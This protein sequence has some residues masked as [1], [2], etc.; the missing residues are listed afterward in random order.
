MRLPA[1]SWLGLS[2]SEQPRKR[3]LAW[4]GEGVGSGKDTKYTLL[5]NS[6]GETW[7]G[8]PLSIVDVVED[9][10]RPDSINVWYS[11]SYDVNML[12]RNQPK[13]T[14]SE[15][16]AATCRMCGMNLQAKDS[17]PLCK[18]SKDGKG[19]HVL[20]QTVLDVGGSDYLIEYFPKKIFRVTDSERN[21]GVHYDSFS[22][23]ARSFIK[24][25]AMCK[26]PVP[27][28]ITDGKA[29]RDNFSAWK[30]E[31]IQ[32]YN[33]AEVQS[34]VKVMDMLRDALDTIGY[35]DLSGWHGP[36]AIASAM[37]DRLGVYESM[38]GDAVRKSISKKLYSRLAG[39]KG[40]AFAAYYGGRNELIRRGEVKP[41]EN[42]D[43]QSAYPAATRELPAF[44]VNWRNRIEQIAA[45]KKMEDAVAA[46]WI[47]VE[48]KDAL[49]S[50]FG[51]VDV[52]WKCDD[53]QMPLGPFPFRVGFNS[54]LPE[55]N[56]VFPSSLR[57]SDELKK[58]KKNSILYPPVGQGSY[59]L[60]EVR[61]AVERG[62]W[63]VEIGKG[64]A[65]KAGYEKPLYEPISAMMTK[66]IQYKKDG[67]FAHLPI[68]LGAN[69]FFGKFAQKFLETREYG[70]YNNMLCAG[71]IMAWCRAEIMKYLDPWE[72]VMITT[73]GLYSKTALKC[74]TGDDLGTWEY[75]HYDSGRFI[76]P[77]IYELVK[78]GKREAPKTRG[79]PEIKDFDWAYAECMLG[80]KVPLKQRMFVPIR[81]SLKSYRKYPK[82]GFYE[83][84][85]EIDPDIVDQKRRIS[86]RAS[87]QLSLPFW[88]V[89]DREDETQSKL[90][91][92]FGKLKKGWSEAD[93]DLVAE[94]DS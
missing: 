83:I 37:M 63:D 81:K 76:L 88:P 85:R 31:D 43:I 89:V 55:D 24:T 34:L 91:E 29:A 8:N 40:L 39:A 11:F 35:A 51:I 10:I 68:K 38:S 58:L 44:V 36:G 25:L 33:L 70:R 17:V 50:E 64:F 15:L 62:F 3:F 19:R 59:H 80:R 21:R 18:S 57:Y 23:F 78:D 28:I 69:S 12:F 65:L 9:L 6:D 72:L 94:E 54:F 79:Y 71:F 22:F 52:K 86:S 74:P 16:F 66:R 13:Q 73:D 30:A 7:T 46:E 56:I 20:H 75:N 14:L 49:K 90:F 32:R 77:G 61:S 26:I 45:E 93:Q 92:P 4:D 53:P 2:K 1:R 48:G 87:D 67:N 84:D 47:P 42:Y 27:Q 60:C 41:V 5:Q 82:C